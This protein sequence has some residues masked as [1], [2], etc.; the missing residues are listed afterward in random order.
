VSTRNPVVVRL[1][2]ACIIGLQLGL[3]L[4]NASTYS[5][6]IDEPAH[7]LSGLRIWQAGHVD[8]YL[9]NP[10][11]IRM[12]ASLAIPACIP[13][14][15][16][17]SETGGN[18]DSFLAGRR[19]IES[20]GFAANR[21]VY[22]ARCLCIPYCLLGGI[23]CFL[24]ARD[25]YGESAGLAACI[26]WSLSP[27]VLGHGC[28]VTPDVHATALL[29][30]AA[31]FYWIWLRNTTW[32]TTFLAGVTLGMAALAKATVLVCFPVWFCLW[33]ARRAFEGASSKPDRPLLKLLFLYFLGFYVVALGYGFE[34]IPS[35]PSELAFKSKSLTGVFGNGVDPGDS[36]WLHYLIGRI[37]LPLPH[38]YLSGIDQQLCHFE[39]PLTQSYLNGKFRND[40]WW[41]FYSVA[42]A[43]KWP[44]GVLA[45]LVLSFCYAP[46]QIREIVKS[47]ALA[48]GSTAQAEMSV[49]RFDGLLVLAAGLAIFAFVSSK[50]GMNKHPRY[51]FPAY[52]FLFVWVSQLWNP[53]LN[54]RKCAIGLGAM[55]RFWGIPVKLTAT[56]LLLHASLVSVFASPNHLSYFNELAGGMRGGPQNL[57]DS[58]V[59]WGQDLYRL[60]AWRA[61]HQDTTLYVALYCD[62]DPRSLGIDSLP[63]VRPDRVER[64]PEGYYAISVSILRGMPWFSSPEAD[65]TIHVYPLNAF[66]EF[67]FK[68][69]IGY[70]GGSIVIFKVEPVVRQGSSGAISKAMPE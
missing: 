48:A 66:E 45:I 40:G 30:F 32:T 26:L 69:S 42:I 24:W 15:R 2:L 7:L 67:Q 36:T 12:T 22:Y 34:G 16:A 33:L 70:I 38:N 27:D 28:L 46:F 61:E 51:A 1:A 25:L 5:P 56:I 55:R 13:S 10:P 4:R 35:Q 63:S 53:D 65:G 68:R 52:P 23:A 60:Q 59:D 58:A 8:S 29:A 31:Y 57:I 11:L 43:V 19:F 44:V 50:T 21:A 20:H 39:A 18:W 14:L 54:C 41:Y 49:R 62:V 3:L 64:L 47:P 37:P 9:V 6:T 17:D